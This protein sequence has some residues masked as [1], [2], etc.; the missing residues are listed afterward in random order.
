MNDHPFWYF[1]IVPSWLGTWRPKASRSFPSSILII[2]KY[3]CRHSQSNWRYNLLF[4]FHH[5]VFLRHPKNTLRQVLTRFKFEVYNYNIY[6]M[7][8]SLRLMKIT[9]AENEWI[10]ITTTPGDSWRTINTN[11]QWIV[12]LTNR[13]LLGFYY[14]KSKG[15]LCVPKRKKRTSMFG[16]FI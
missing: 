12:S 13:F 7:I 6:W 14:K 16:I 9:D 15:I 1:C 5:H 4:S 3:L 10:L 11:W 8:Y 2:T